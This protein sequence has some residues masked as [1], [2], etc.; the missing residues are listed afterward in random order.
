[1]KRAGDATERKEE[2]EEVGPGGDEAVPGGGGGE[3]ASSGED[4][5]EVADVAAEQGAEGESAGGTKGQSQPS[6]RA[7]RSQ[8]TLSDGRVVSSHVRNHVNPLLPHFQKPVPVPCGGD[9][10]KVFKDPSLPFVLDIGC[11][12]GRFCLE[13]AK[14]FPA[15]NW[16]GVEIR[17]ALVVRANQWVQEEKLGNLHY[18]FGNASAGMAELL[19]SM[20]ADGLRHVTIQCPDPWFKKKHQKRRMLTQRLAEELA[21]NMPSESTIFVQSDVEQVAMQMSD[22]LAATG[23][24]ARVD[25]IPTLAESSA[26]AAGGDAAAQSPAGAGA[27]APVPRP[28]AT[29]GRDYQ[30]KAVGG[31]EW[32]HKGAA[33]AADG[34]YAW[35]SENPLGLMSERESSTISRGLPIFRALFRP[36]GA[37][38]SGAATASAEPADAKT[39]TAAA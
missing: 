39:E 12:K 29:A 2:D 24:F 13:G 31:G 4:D 23:G 3:G 8:V 36:N 35:L 22:F 32:E 18:I 11:A 34:S 38:A 17:E 27:I 21:A 10:S 30:D 28:R 26:A 20:P 19:R 7:K 5:D 6:K 33:A 1:M 37:A 16:I 9:W 14:R 15:F 25:R